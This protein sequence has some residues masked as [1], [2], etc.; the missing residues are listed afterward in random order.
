MVGMGDG[1]LK[2][3][4]VHVAWNRRMLRGEKGRFG[5]GLS[6]WVENVIRFQK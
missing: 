1:D 4:G 2:T 3:E 6:S 5:D